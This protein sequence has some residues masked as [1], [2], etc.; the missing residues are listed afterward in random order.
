MEGPVQEKLIAFI[1]RHGSTL[2]NAGNFFRGWGAI[3]LDDQGYEQARAMRDFLKD[4]PIE[5]IICSPLPRARAT[6]GIVAEPHRLPVQQ[7]GDLLPWHIGMF[8]GESKDE[9]QDALRLFVKNP[10][11]QVPKG[12]SLEEFESR[13]FAFWEQMLK[14]EVLSLFVAHTSNVTALVNFTE[15][16]D[17]VEPEFGDSVEPGGV[18][19]VYFNGKKYRFEPVF[20]GEEK[21]RFGGS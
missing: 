9:A 2:L 21:A 10:Y 12:E 18:G 4:Q 3:D 1:G 13:Q 6:A 7:T 8:A 19:A 20:G 11:V 17:E 5:Q 14:S 16:A 15:G